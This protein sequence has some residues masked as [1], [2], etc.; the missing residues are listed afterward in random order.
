MRIGPIAT[1]SL[2]FCVSPEPKRQIYIQ[3]LPNAAHGSVTDAGDA[4]QRQAARI[5]GTGVLVKLNFQ[6]SS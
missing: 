4:A 6:F 1:D 3:H 2:G 5:A